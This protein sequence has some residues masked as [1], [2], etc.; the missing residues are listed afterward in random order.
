[1]LV[2]LRVENLGVIDE[3]G[4]V[5]EPGMTAL[6]GETGAGKTLV[7]G[8]IELLMG[9]RADPVQVRLGAEEARVEGRFL[10]GDSEVVLARAVPRAGRSR[11]YVD[12]RLATAAELAEVGRSLV[13]LHGQNTHQ[14]LSSVTTQRAAL[15]RF[16]KVDLAPLTEAHDR[17]TEIG[18]QLQRL[19]GDAR[20]RAR[21]VDL[22]R[23]QVAELADA[24]VD[25]P[26]EDARLEEEEDA[27]A[28]AD[29][30]RVAGLMAYDALMGEG[31][32]SDAVG[33]ALGACSGRRPFR[34]VE[35][36]LKSLS[37]ELAEA[38]SNLRNAVDAIP[39]DPGRLEEVRGRRRLLRELTRKYGEQLSD[40][41]KFE[42][43]A[44]ARLAELEARDDRLVAL[45]SELDQARS[46]AE[47]AAD[48]VGK[49]RRDA[50]PRLGRDIE[51]NL[52]T[53]AMPSARFEVSVGGGPAG[54][55][56]EFLLG[57]N[58]GQPALPLGKTAS[59]GEL[60]RAMLAAR[61]VLSDAPPTLIFDEV[62]AGVGGAA[63]VSIGRALAS[64]SADRQVV[65]VTHLPQ[66]AAFADN[67][68]AVTK[69]EREGR[70]LVQALALPRTDRIVELSRML[71]GQPASATARE[72]A[73]EMLA[74]A[75]RERGLDSSVVS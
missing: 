14:S 6:T 65:V 54:E 12:G 46:A 62:D 10:S 27:L 8:A 66:V 19:G 71:S 9:G 21:E 64:L 39:D 68:V 33:R 36:T 73:E 63:A 26:D 5:F 69:S 37:A 48:A 57:A 55:D 22:L 18:V 60:A 15:D 59:G 72:H 13:D 30:H 53:L 16:G 29:A 3:L 74:A 4:L 25:D 47:R 35:G 23:F 44:K 51:R 61:L 1:M 2:E 56:V 24:L 49:E 28:D 32:G 40:V 52:R 34:A 11:A 45:E 58:P 75:S 20:A 7:V 41:I 67:Q 70:T 31:A 43:D 42:A 50:A 38:A 17:L